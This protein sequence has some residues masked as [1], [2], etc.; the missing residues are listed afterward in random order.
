MR[1]TLTTITMEHVSIMA[2]DLRRL[3]CDICGRCCA[4]ASPSSPLSTVSQGVFSMSPSC[5]M[6]VGD[7]NHFECEGGD[8]GRCKMNAHLPLCK[9]FRHL[10][11]A[12][13]AISSA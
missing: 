2:V 11:L 4:A 6:A 9:Y 3:G 5:D 10:L 13:D 7:R 1:Y 8:L 12:A